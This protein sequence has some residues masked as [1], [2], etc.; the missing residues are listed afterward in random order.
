MSDKLFRILAVLLLAGILGLQAYTVFKPAPVVPGP[1]KNCEDALRLADV[2]LAKHQAFLGNI[3]DQY[4]A[5]V[6]DRASNINQQLLLSNEDT[7]LLL[8]DAATVRAAMDK[9]TLYCD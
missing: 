8:L 7:F 6:Y 3:L 9:I 1:D 5:D 4:E 2:A